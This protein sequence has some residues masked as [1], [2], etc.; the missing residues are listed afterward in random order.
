[1]APR[2]GTPAV[3]VIVP[4]RDAAPTLRRTLDALRAQVPADTFEV[5]VVD[6]GSGDE[7]SAIAE[8][9]APFVKLI[10]N[11]ISH[12]PGAARNL[13]AR[14]SR[15]PI[16]AFTDADCF[17][18]SR[19]LAKG[20]VAMTNADLVQGAVRP[21]PSSAR[22]PFDRTLEVDRDGAFYQTANL[23]VRRELFDAVGGFRDWSLERNIRLTWATD[24]RPKRLR[25]TPPGEDALFGWTARRLGARTAFCSDALVYHAVVR[26]SV[27]DEMADRWHWTRKMPGLV[28]LVPE[29]RDAVFYQRWF[30][31]RKTARFDIALMGLA[32][33]L[34]TRRMHWLA[35]ALPY[36]D[37]VGRESARWGLRRAPE[38]VLGSVAVDAVT[39]GGLLTGSVRWRRLVL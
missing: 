11:E 20:L 6:D 39:L 4:A 17:P 24:R 9:Y 12:G 22:S 34:I 10:R 15:A 30:F 8:R 1:M 31:H 7:T 33:A 3:T 23:L 26:R 37:W 14:A 19:W 32:A 27:A 16:L 2:L 13:G 25:P 5:I 21:D 29:L 38:F 18:T 35:A 36:A 28:R